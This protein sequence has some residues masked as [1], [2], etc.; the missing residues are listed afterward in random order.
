MKTKLIFLIVALA[1]LG[2]CAQLP[3]LHPLAPM[4]YKALHEKAEQG[5][6]AAQVKVALAQFR[7]CYPIPDDPE[8]KPACDKTECSKWHHMAAAN[9]DPAARQRL[10]S[11]YLGQYRSG[12]ECGIEENIKQGLSWYHKAASEGSMP[13]NFALAILYKEGKYV[14]QSYAEAAKWY[15]KAA[16]TSTADCTSAAAELSKMYALGQGVPKDAQKAREWGL[17]AAQA[18]VRNKFELGA[19]YATTTPP[20][21]AE[22]YYWTSLARPALAR[23]PLGAGF[24]ASDY[25]KFW[26]AEKFEKHL[27]AEQ[28]SDVKKRVENETL[29]LCKEGTERDRYYFCPESKK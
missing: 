24:I 19:L 20:D 8:W 6:K 3:A 5:D 4:E 1:F 23:D 11:L 28:I 10:A 21:Y 16:E 25:Y 7:A 15:H 22:A 13:A 2:G 27:T 26:F 18:S 9:G 17:K 12:K 29:R 14:K